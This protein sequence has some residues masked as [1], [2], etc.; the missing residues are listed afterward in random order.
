MG[1]A[2]QTH[3]LTV[4]SYLSNSGEPYSVQG[5]LAVPHWKKAMYDEYSALHRNKTWTLVP[6][7]LGRNLIDYK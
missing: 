2:N 6:Q 4:L 3:T 5:A 7:Q 1:L